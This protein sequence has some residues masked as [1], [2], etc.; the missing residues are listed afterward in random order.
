[1]DTIAVELARFHPGQI[2]VPDSIGSFAEADAMRLL[3]LV[4]PIE[5]AEFDEFR[6]GGI[7]CKVN[8]RTI[9]SCSLREGLPGL[10]RL[11][12]DGQ[13]LA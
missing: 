8:A 7:K 4:R 1:M 9:P 3:R 12:Q 2:N 10:I 5:Q 6:R 11:T 13:P